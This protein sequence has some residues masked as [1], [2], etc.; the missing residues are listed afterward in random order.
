MSRPPHE[1]FVVVRRGEEFLVV[2]R[3]PRGGA[4]WHGISGGVEDGESYTD[5]ASRE[6]FEETG[7]TARPVEIAAPFVYRTE[8]APDGITV[9]CYL[10]DVPAA[11]EPSLNDEHDDYRWCTRDAAVELLEWPEPKALMRSL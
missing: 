3:T 2:H 6:L 5:A 11:W 7:L 1:V 8:A 4:Y 10:V 9:G